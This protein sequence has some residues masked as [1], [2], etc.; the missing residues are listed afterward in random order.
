MS[1]LAC[2]PMRCECVRQRCGSEHYLTVRTIEH[3]IFGG[4]GRSVFG[5]AGFLS[6]RAIFGI[7]KWV[8]WFTTTR[9]WKEAS[10]AGGSVLRCRRVENFSLV[11]GL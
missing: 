10:E 5:R 6:L 4:V 1:L 7:F 3:V 2:E 9:Q 11:R 8:V